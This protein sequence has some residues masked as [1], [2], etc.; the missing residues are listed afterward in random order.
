MSNA[1]TMFVREHGRHG[2]AL[3]LGEPA[4]RGPSA[5]YGDEVLV[6]GGTGERSAGGRSTLSRGR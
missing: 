6:P 5:R 3:A 2:P 1:P 4:V